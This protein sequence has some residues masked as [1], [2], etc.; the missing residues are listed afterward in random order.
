MTDQNKRKL[1]IPNPTAGK[2]LQRMPQGNSPMKKLGYRLF[3]GKTT[4]FKLSDRIIRQSI[5]K[6]KIKGIKLKRKI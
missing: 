6:P 2:Y 3:K 5:K 1:P 4:A